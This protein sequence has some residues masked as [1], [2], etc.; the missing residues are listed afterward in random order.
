MTAKRLG[1]LFVSSSLLLGEAGVW[2]GP[3]LQDGPLIVE[4]YGSEDS[5]PRFALGAK[6]GDTLRVAVGGTLANPRLSAPLL[7][8]ILENLGLDAIALGY[9]DLVRA[10][11]AD[12]KTVLSSP[13]IPIVCA[14]VAGAGRK[15]VV[16]PRGSRRI[17]FV[18]VTAPPA[19]LAPPSAGA[20]K[21]EPP[22][23]ALQSLLPEVSK[24]ADLI[25]LLAAMDRIEGARLL[26]KFPQIAVAIVPALGGRDPEPLRIGDSW[27][28]QSCVEPSAFSRLTLTLEGRQVSKA[29]NTVE[30]AGLTPKELE[31]SKALFAKHKAPPLAPRLV[32]AGGA[33]GPPPA[34]PPPARLELGKS[35]A[36]GIDRSNRAAEIRFHV[37]HLREAYGGKKAP[38]GGAWLVVDTE[39]K[40]I[41]PMTYVFERRVPTTYKILEAANHL[42]AVIDGK[43]VARL[44]PALCE[45]PGGLL[46]KGSLVLETL[47]TT[48]RGDLVF[49]LPRPSFDSL[50]LRFYDYS[51]GHFSLTLVA[52][53][54]QPGLAPPA[55]LLPFV[56]NEVLELGVFAFRRTPSLKEATAPPGM[57][58][59]EVDL[60]A[61]SAMMLEAD[62]T[63]FDPKAAPNSKMQMGTVAD[64]KD[65]RKHLHLI[66]DGEYA[67][68]LHDP[69]EL[70]EAPRFLPDLPTGATLVFLIPE[71]AES[72]ELRCDF[73]NAALPGGKVIHPKALTVLLEGKRPPTPPREPIVEIDDGIFKV[74]VVGQTVLR[75]FASE[76]A[77]AGQA[78]LVLDLVVRNTGTGTEFFQT[79][80]QLKYAT[81][82]GQSLGL[83]DATFRGIRA[84]GNLVLVPP[85][86]PRSFQAVFAIPETDRRPRLMYSG[87]SKA[88]TVNLRPLEAGAAPEAKKRL[89]PKCG[90]EAG[91]K[92]KFC[93]DCGTKLN[94]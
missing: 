59:A 52:S 67:Y 47:G 88:A 22:E 87:V 91:P 3:G 55:P 20:W 7:E 11:S 78:L 1:F 4:H 2:A 45:G 68:G 62:A 24:E 94:P 92:D 72:V 42:Y 57:S 83:N 64:W 12:F 77:G 60:R 50:E 10:S 25:V 33:A 51:H 26:R 90:R 76:K 30:P 69:V 85:G 75:E 34:V 5:L 29:S 63:A 19:Y 84:P 73:P 9:E 40:N 39:W 49:P 28:V 53:P 32:P 70:P 38:A 8:E 56:A 14:N 61:R 79:R 82:K 15:Y 54:S 21:I 44:E 41:I 71:K 80:E 46:E 27:I 36:L 13:K 31:R 16:R 48:K 66:V 74:A 6:S 43:S 23:A 17:A 81:E 65:A 35:V 58:F 86:E 93:D 37:V 89:C 18:G